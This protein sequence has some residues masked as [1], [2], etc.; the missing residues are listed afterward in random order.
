MKNK[1]G[2]LSTI[3]ISIILVALVMYFVYG[4]ELR[5]IYISDTFFLVGILFLFPGLI[6]ITGATELFSSARYIFKKSFTKSTDGGNH[7][8]SFSDYKEY[9]KERNANHNREFTGVSILVVGVA[10]II[11]SFIIGKIA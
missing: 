7:L 6:F 1:K 11:L 8:I 5:L 10:Y 4:F 9:E 3:V 2:I